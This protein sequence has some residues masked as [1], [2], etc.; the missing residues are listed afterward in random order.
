VTLAHRYRLVERIGEGGMGSVWA[1]EQLSP[2]QRQVAVKMIKPGMNSRQVI[3]RFEMERHALAAMDHPNIAKILDGGVSENGLPYFVMEL[4]NG[5]TLAEYCD[6][7]RLTVAERLALFEKIALAVQHAHQKGILHRDLKPT[8]ILVSTT[9]GQSTPKLIDFGLSKAIDQS[10]TGDSLTTQFG[11]ILGTL[12]YM[13]PEQT[14]LNGQDVDT[15]AD[16][17]SLGVILYELLTGLR[18]FDRELRQA[19]IDEVVRVIREDDP[20]RPSTRLSSSDFVPTAAALRRTDPRK[21]CGILRNELDWIV[22]KALEKDRNRR[23]DSAGEL[24]ADVQRFLAGEALTAHPPSLGYR[25]VKFSR[26][27]RATVVAAGL[28]LASMIFG[29]IAT[30]WQAKLAHQEAARADERSIAA[31]K[32]EADQRRLAESESRQRREAQSQKELAEKAA[33]AEKVRAA[34]LERVANFQRK[35]FEQVDVAQAGRGLAIDLR[36]KFSK[37]MSKSEAPEA[38]RQASINEFT[39]SLKRI[40]LTDAAIEFIDSNVL[41]PAIVELD[42]TR[43]DS[44]LVDATL[45][46]SVAMVYRNLGRF[47]QAI[48]LQREALS[49][50]RRLLGESNLAYVEAL[51]SLAL[52]L[53]EAGRQ[54]ESEPLTREA[55]SL[56][57]KL[58]GDDHIDTLASQNNLGLLLRAQGKPQE[59]EEVFRVNWDRAKKALGEEH[60]STVDLQ[61]NLALVLTE[62]GKLLEAEPLSR[63]LL[64]KR[65]RLD[66]ADNVATIV[67][68]NN[69]GLLLGSLGR[70]DECESQFREALEISRRALGNDHPQTLS[71]LLN[72]G[73]LLWRIQKFDLAEPI[74][75]ESLEKHRQVLGDN[76]PNTLMAI[77]NLATLM[78]AQGRL[79]EAEPL[80]KEALVRSRSVLG[81]DHERTMINTANLAKLLELLDRPDEAEPLWRNVL[82]DFRRVAGNEHPQTISA[83]LGLAK[84][85][86]LLG[87][88]DDGEPFLREALT[89]TIRQQGLGSLGTARAFRLVGQNLIMQSKYAEAEKELLFAW[90]IVAGTQSISV[91]HRRELISSLIDLYER[92]EAAEPQKNYAAKAKDWRKKQDD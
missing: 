51:N 58:N 47:D 39:N 80:R 37:V 88:A 77:N 35:L 28:I 70:Y 22:M 46:H 41:K 60:R 92:W 31:T 59:A 2:I 14:G 73:A 57:Q 56:N 62:L 90:K 84:N 12:E 38:A 29:L 18:P 23:Y 27:H 30:L 10:L 20:A 52:F 72:L 74:Q 64:A 91:D 21:L 89:I 67:A 61:A 69:Y 40:N 85:Q 86:E 50:R 17:Y 66:G 9:D 83:L 78:I 32:A 42:K 54:N 65:I 33:A 43:D 48:A 11:A 3:H 45:R 34:E 87:R 63:D 55:I 79:A 4:V 25:A 1:A 15:R 19:A 49:T 13:A 16:V 8:N 76:H 6:S 24:A 81:L 5:P 68:R 36:T 71:A 7:A 82:G 75:Q 26:R 44:P 53:Q